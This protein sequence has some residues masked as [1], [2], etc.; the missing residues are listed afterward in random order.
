MK[1]SKIKAKV[2]VLPKQDE[3]TLVR[4]LCTTD[5]SIYCCAVDSSHAKAALQRY[6]K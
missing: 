5:G 2:T 3:M 1:G 4:K 6:N